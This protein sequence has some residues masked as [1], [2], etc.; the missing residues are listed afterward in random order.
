MMLGYQVKTHNYTNCEKSGKDDVR[1]N[2][3][4]V[5]EI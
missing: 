1:Q 2:D 5:Y 4:L 3:K